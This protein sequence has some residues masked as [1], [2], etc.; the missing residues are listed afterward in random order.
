VIAPRA[1]EQEAARRN[2]RLLAWCGPVGIVLILGGLWLLAGFLPPPKPSLSAAGIAATYA[3]DSTGIRL[4]LFLAI[5]G[6]SLFAPFGAAI[7]TQMLRI[8]GHRRPALVYTQLINAS[9]GAFVLM[10]AFIIM[11]VAAFDPSRPVEITKV[12]NELGWICLVIPFAPFCIQYVAITIAIFQ[13]RS[14]TPVFP[15]WVAY[16]NI[17]IA[18]GFIPTGFVGFFH[19]G[20]FAWNGVIAFWL[21]LSLYAGWFVVMTWAVL[22]AVR[23]DDGTT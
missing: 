22:R 3:D 13:D 12:I 9:L 16:Y 10:L 21:A 18:V 6:T 23:L 2:Q 15:R 17:W 20:P 1:E 7:S 8:E 5:A 4:G 14:E 19:T 11:M